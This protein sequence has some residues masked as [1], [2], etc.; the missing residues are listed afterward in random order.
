MCFSQTDFQ[1]NE[2]RQKLIVI[3][4][5]VI[6]VPPLQPFSKLTTKQTRVFNVKLQEYIAN[7]PE[8]YLEVIDKDFN[9]VMNDVFER[10]KPEEQFVRNMNTDVI[11][12]NVE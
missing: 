3:I 8:N 1:N 9:M 4:N 5:D 2:I 11:P 10:F 6:G 12:L 7:L